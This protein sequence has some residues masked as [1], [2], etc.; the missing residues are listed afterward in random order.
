MGRSSGVLQAAREAEI[1]GLKSATG[2]TKD[3][4]AARQLEIEKQVFALEQQKATAT[5]AIRL[6]E[7]QIYTIQQGKLL[8]AQNSLTVA[9][10]ELLNINDRKDA[11]LDRINQLKQFYADDH[12]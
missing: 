12:K 7:D 3:Q 2:L 5:A 1:A 10:D 6:Q 4:I 11:D 8:T 9:R